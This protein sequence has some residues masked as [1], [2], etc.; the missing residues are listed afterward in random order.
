MEWRSH[1]ESS[2]SKKKYNLETVANFDLVSTFEYLFETIKLDSID[3]ISHSGGGIAMTMFLIHHPTYTSKINSITLFAV[4]AFGAGTKFESRTKL[5]FGKYVAAMLGKVPA[6]TAGSVEGSE[7][8][9]T[10]KQW[11]DWNLNNNFIGES[12][13]D[14]LERM[15]T[16]KIP[17]LSICSK[18]DEFVAPKLGCE[19]YLNAFENDENRLHYCSIENGSLENYNHSRII[20]SRN[21]QKELY[22]VVLNWLAEKTIANKELR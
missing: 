10:I 14:Y 2:E 12:N 6:K 22:P 5:R 18:G 7:S 9:Y 15:K 1:G 16:I 17:I 21:A 3:S 8:Y 11:F 19:Q 20:L 4:Q 13:F